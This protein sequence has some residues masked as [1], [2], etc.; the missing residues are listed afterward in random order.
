MRILKWQ[1]SEIVYDDSRKKEDTRFIEAGRDEN[2]E[3][4][5]AERILLYRNLSYPALWNQQEIP[6]NELPQLLRKEKTPQIRGR[7]ANLARKS[8]ATIETISLCIP[9][10][11]RAFPR[12]EVAL[13]IFATNLYD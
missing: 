10:T 6:L 9:Y 13:S 7:H 3:Q 5:L 11:I 4:K 2:I 8:A 1:D 12:S